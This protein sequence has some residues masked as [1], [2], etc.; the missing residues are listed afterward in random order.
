MREGFFVMLLGSYEQII[1]GELCAVYISVLISVHMT[2]GFTNY[3][4][5]DFAKMKGWVEVEEEFYALDDCAGA[6]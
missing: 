3:V 1:I 5:E 6:V 4:G 2:V